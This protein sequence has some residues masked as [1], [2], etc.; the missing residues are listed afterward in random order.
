MEYFND[1]FDHFYTLSRV[2]SCVCG[3]QSKCSAARLQRRNKTQFT[4]HGTSP[5]V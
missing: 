3:K 4:A 1:I 2:D 5:S